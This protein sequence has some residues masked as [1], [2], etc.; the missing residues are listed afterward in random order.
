MASNVGEDLG[1]QPE[2]ADGFAISP[3]L[4]GRHGRCEL[5]VLHTERIE[6]FG[7]CNLGLGVKKRVGELLPLYYQTE[8]K[9]DQTS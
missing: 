2:L 9:S 8:K 4:L 6:G 5:D 1:L 7:D 3:G